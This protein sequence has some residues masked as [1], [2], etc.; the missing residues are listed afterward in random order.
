MNWL[1][2]NVIADM[3]GPYFLLFYAGVI[4]TVIVA[5]FKSVR[6]ADRTGDLEPPEISTKIDPY[7]IAYLRGGENEVTRVAIASLIQRG[8]LQITE[9]KK[10]F[11][12]IKVIDGGRKP[13]PGELA[14]IESCVL[15]WP[16]FPSPPA[17]LFQPSGIP[18]L[19]APACIAHELK[20][21]EDN[22]LRPEDMKKVGTRMFVVGWMIIFGLGLYKMAVG[23]AKGHSNVAFLIVFGLVGLGLLCVACLVLPRTSRRGKAYLV[24]LKLA[25]GELP[26]RIR[27]DE[28]GAPVLIGT[29]KQDV[30]DGSRGTPAYSDSLLVIGIFGMA[31][32]AGT[33]LADLTT[34]FARGGSSS[35]CGGGCGGGGCGGGGCGGGGCGGG[36]CGGGCGGCGGG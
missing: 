13:A 36:G 32:L 26:C 16:G 31:S 19:V 14:P 1:M 21:A 30:R 3:Y 17:S 10:W 18:S 24:R 27:W 34:M 2:H 22:L 25:F 9:Q 6:A 8:L 28:Q 7:E 4:V 23:L 15:G 20:L 11:G 29:N 33:P 35:G 5:C 12:E